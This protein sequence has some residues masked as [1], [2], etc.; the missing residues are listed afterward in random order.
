MS[1][2]FHYQFFSAYYHRCI[3]PFKVG[4]CP[5]MQITNVHKNAQY[6]TWTSCKWGF[7]RPDTSGGLDQV[8]VNTNCHPNPII[9]SERWQWKREGCCSFILALFCSGTRTSNDSAGVEDVLG[10]E[11]ESVEWGGLIKVG[12]LSPALSVGVPLQPALEPHSKN[13]DSN[14]WITCAASCWSNG[15]QIDNHVGLK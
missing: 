5:C 13:T 6:H 12:L 9:W 7:N 1:A 2:R 8:S 14:C 3:L 10:S 4:D 15:H 11:S